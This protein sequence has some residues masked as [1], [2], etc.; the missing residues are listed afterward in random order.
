MFIEGEN[1]V[2]LLEHL[3]YYMGLVPI[4]VNDS[5]KDPVV[6]GLQY[7]LIKIGDVE[8]CCLHYKNC[9][10]AI[11]AWERRKKR[12]DYDNV[13]VLANTWDL[14]ENEELINRLYKTGFKT[15]VLTTNK[16]FK[17]DSKM[18]YINGDFTLDE[19]G[20]PVPSPINYIDKNAYRYFEKYFDFIGWL[21]E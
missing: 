5:Y 6:T 15:I 10:S 3:E 7:P 17:Y 14:D 12:I 4:A 16:K 20:N 8:L 9:V 1:F 21:T 19:K 11:D 2:K 18:V 13:Y